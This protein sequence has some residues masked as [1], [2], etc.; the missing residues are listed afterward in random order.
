MKLKDLKLSV[1]AFLFIVS[2]SFTTD[3]DDSKKLDKPKEPEKP[4]CPAWVHNAVF[5]EIYP[6]TFY[7][8]NNDGIGDLNGITQ[9]LDYVKSLGVTAV[10]L[11]PFYESPFKD[12]G[13][14]VSDFYKVAPRYGTEEDINNLIKEA[15]NKGLKLIIDFVPGH[16]SIDHPWFKAAAE[17]KPNKYSNW[18]IWTNS[19]W[20]NGGPEFAG[21]MV[22]GY[23]ERDGN[24]M[25]NFFWHQPALNFGFGKTDPSKPWQLAVNHPDVLAL[26]EE[27]KNVMRYWLKKGVDGFRVDMAGSLVKNDVNHD[28]SKWWLEVRQMM[29]KE[30]PNTFMVSEWSHPKSAIDGGFH[31]DFFHWFKEYEDLFRKESWRSLNGFSEGH[32]YFD[33]EGK[34]DIKEFLNTY[35]DQYNQTKD[36]GYISIPVGN[37]DLSRVNIKRT[38]KDLEIIYTFLLTMPGVPFMYNGDEIGMRQLYDLPYKEGCYKPRAGARTPMQWSRSANLGFSKAPADKLY[39]A[40]DG[41]ADAP[42]VS[43]QEANPNS[44]LNH[45]KKLFV[46]RRDEKALAA[47]AEF[48]PLFA[49]KN[50]YPFVYLRSNGN[51]KMLVCLNPSG[52]DA[53]ASFQ[54]NLGKKKPKL[55]AG[56]EQK[57]SNKSNNISLQMKGQSFAVYKIVE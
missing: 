27:M 20:H 13:Y 24:Y 56:E 22:N 40:V 53:T 42:V 21:K 36:K 14:D 9:K 30:F 55:V 54:L 16:T 47:Y 23:S 1:L 2:S 39:L 49:E 38:D 8:S 57:L 33:K 28:C 37:H 15:H 48:T 26:R 3:P 45:L 31:S 44:L 50:K 32:S 17:P 43:E 41:A 19:T 4:N 34:G 35:L 25:T 7:D 5:Y 12:A 52:Q 10:W 46:L 29:E 51:E 18:Y 11:N 6:Q